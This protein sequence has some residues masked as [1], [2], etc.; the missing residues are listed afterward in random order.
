MGC[1]QSALSKQNH[2]SKN[3]FQAPSKSKKRTK[4]EPKTPPLSDSQMGKSSSKSGSSSTFASARMDSARAKTHQNQSNNSD[5][6]RSNSVLS[7][8]SRASKTSRT[9]K[10]SQHLKI[11][12][13]ANNNNNNLKRNDDGDSCRSSASSGRSSISIR[14]FLCENTSD[15]EEE[16]ENLKPTRSRSASPRRATGRV[17]ALKETQKEPSSARTSRRMFVSRLKRPKSP[18]MCKIGG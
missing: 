11:D 18:Q 8:A 9:S 1:G 14:S 12:G 15:G 16:E 3:S 7:R 17:A 2:S 10:L 5:V 6:S 13:L 4:N